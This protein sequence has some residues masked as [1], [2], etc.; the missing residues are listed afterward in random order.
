MTRKL[1][2]NSSLFFTN[3]RLT[4]RIR[5]L[6]A[7][8]DIVVRFDLAEDN[9]VDDE[10]LGKLDQ[11]QFFG[12]QRDGSESDQIASSFPAFAVVMIALSARHQMT[13]P[14]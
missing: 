2:R 9:V 13:H 11:L 10:R 6:D 3:H 14:C 4:S 12:M 1:D 8:S 7:T 5:W